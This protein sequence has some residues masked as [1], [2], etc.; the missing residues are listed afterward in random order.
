MT[1]IDWW[2]K[3]PLYFLDV[4]N[5]IKYIRA[6]FWIIHQKR[7]WANC[8]NYLEKYLSWHVIDF[9]QS[10]SHVQLFATPWTA[11]QQASLSLTTSQNLPKFISTELVMQSNHLI[12][13]CPLLLLPSIFFP[14]IDSAYMIL[15]DVQT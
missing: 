7:A 1:L 11:K 2:C 8:S 9:V 15:L 14:V 13:C 4:Y 12:L 5:Q 10:T 6:K 3:Y